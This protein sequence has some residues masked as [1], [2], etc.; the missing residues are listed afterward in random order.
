MVNFGRPMGFD[1]TVLM[2]ILIRKREE[3]R[4]ENKR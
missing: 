4:G 1:S 3:V 2:M